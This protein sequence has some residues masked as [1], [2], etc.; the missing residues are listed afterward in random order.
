[1]HKNVTVINVAQL[2]GTINVEIFSEVSTN[3]SLNVL[4]IVSDCILNSI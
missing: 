4:L 2:I 3:S 1:M